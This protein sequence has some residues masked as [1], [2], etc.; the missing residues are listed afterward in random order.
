MTPATLDV[1]DSQILA[2]LRVVM[3]EALPAGTEVIQAYGNMVPEPLTPDFVVLSPLQRERLSTNRDRDIDII[4][5]NGDGSLTY[6]GKH[7]IN[8]TTD[9]SIQL[10]VHG[11]TSAANAM[12][13]Q[14]LAW[15][16]WANQELRRIP[17][18]PDMQLLFATSA[19]QIPFQ[20][21]EQ[22]WEFRWVM[23]WHVQ[24]NQTVS[25]FQDFA[26]HLNAGLINVGVVYPP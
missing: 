3:L 13:L 10:D 21:A 26:D 9:F 18:G 17:N 4:L 19:H 14:A 25:L 23:E 12:V 1:T 7:L 24:A 22:Q 2:G 16:D 6:A 8:F 20:N 11:P 15:N 5:T